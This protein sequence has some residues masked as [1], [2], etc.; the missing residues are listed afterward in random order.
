MYVPVHPLIYS[1]S[2][3]LSIYQPHS[4]SNISTYLSTYLSISYPSTN[5]FI[6]QSIQIYT[7]TD[8]PF[9]SLTAR[10]AGR[11]SR[12]AQKGRPPVPSRMTPSPSSAR[13]GRATRAGQSTPRS[14]PWC[15][16]DT[17]L[18]SCRWILK[19]VSR[20]FM[21]PFSLSPLMSTVTKD[22]QRWLIIFFCNLFYLFIF[23]F[24]LS[25]CKLLF[26][27]LNYFFLFF[28]YLFMYLFIIIFTALSFPRLSISSF[29]RFE[30]FLHN[31]LFSFLWFSS[32]YELSFPSVL[33]R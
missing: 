17:T 5:P 4:T 21:P 15:R 24:F 29:L 3:H 13:G 27:A 19:E 30:L 14:E 33:Q 32:S 8:H 1:T 9:L 16:R 10:M 25:R 31:V 23:S 6:N 22:P 11:W 2:L 12:G 28:N 26:P 18:T 20:V 7:H